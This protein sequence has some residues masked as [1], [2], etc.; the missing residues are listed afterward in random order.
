MQ[1]S[2]GGSRG[3]CLRGTRLSKIGIQDVDEYQPWSV[4]QGMC[5]RCTYFNVDS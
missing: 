5:E 1:G 2:R 4:I 3:F